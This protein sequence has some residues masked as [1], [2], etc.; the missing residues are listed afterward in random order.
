MNAEFIATHL[1]LL[2]ASLFFKTYKLPEIGAIL[3]LVEQKC[4]VWHDVERCFE[5]LQYL[6]EKLKEMKETLLYFATSDFLGSFSNREEEYKDFQFPTDLSSSCQEFFNKLFDPAYT[7]GNNYD[8][9]DLIEFIQFTV[10]F[11]EAS[12]E[13]IN[14]ALSL[15]DEVTQLMCAKYEWLI[16]NNASFIEVDRD[17]KPCDCFEYEMSGDCSCVFD[18]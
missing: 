8:L 10:Q 3:G 4:K 15:L 16:P 7:P 11:K 13:R 12:P 5:N 6:N 9:D 14:E 17:T 18:C 1:K 2:F